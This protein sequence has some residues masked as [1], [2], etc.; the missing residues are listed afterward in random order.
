GILAVKMN[1]IEN[2][3]LFEAMGIWFLDRQKSL[4]EILVDRDVLSSKNCELL[5]TMVRESQARAVLGGPPRDGPDAPTRASESI[6]PTEACQE[7]QEPPEILARASESIRPT[8]PPWG[9]FVRLPTVEVG[10]APDDV[11]VVWPAPSEVGGDERFMV[12]R[13]HAKGGIGKVSV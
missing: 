1:F 8:Q 11:T 4:G 3:D 9:E 7:Q 12:L 13:P 2:E 6:R 5:D 10:S